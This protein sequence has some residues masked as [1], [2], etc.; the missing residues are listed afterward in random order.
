MTERTSLGTCSVGSATDT[1]CP[2]EAVWR[3]GEEGSRYCERHLMVIRTRE[4]IEEA[5]IILAR[6]LESVRVWASEA[7]GR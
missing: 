3:E 4:A 6:H 5:E 2:R 7:N 1:P